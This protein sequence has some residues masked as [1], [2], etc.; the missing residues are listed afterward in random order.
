MFVVDNADHVRR[1]FL[2][3]FILFRLHDALLIEAVQPVGDDADIVFWQVGDAIGIVRGELAHHA[4]L[5]GDV[6]VVIG[7]ILPHDAVAFAFDSGVGL[8]NREVEGCCQLLILPWLSE[9]DMEGVVGIVWH[10]PNDDGY[11]AYH[12]CGT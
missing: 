5:G 11:G 6:E 1:V 10:G 2:Q 7:L 8:V 4:G 3:L 9:L 12:K